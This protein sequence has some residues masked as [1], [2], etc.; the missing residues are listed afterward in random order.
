MIGVATTVRQEDVPLS[1]RRCY[2]GQL[3][4]KLT[5][6]QLTNL[7]EDFTPLEQGWYMV[8]KSQGPSP[9]DDP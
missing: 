7:H 3:S 6:L 1:T 8:G 5:A 2:D 4:G 9:V